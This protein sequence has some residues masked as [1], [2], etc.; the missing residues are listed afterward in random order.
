MD[1]KVDE[2]LPNRVA[3]LLAEHGHAAAT[4]RAQGMGGW[5]DDRL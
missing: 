1:I 5:K 2:D 3:D 4:V